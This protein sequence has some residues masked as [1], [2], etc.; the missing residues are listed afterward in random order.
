MK[1]IFSTP[2]AAFFLTVVVA[3]LALLGVSPVSEAVRAMSLPLAAVT[4]TLVLAVYG[5][6]DPRPQPRWW[7]K[8]TFAALYLVA[9]LVITALAGQID[10]WY[11]RFGVWCLVAYLLSGLILAAAIMYH[12]L[13]NPLGRATQRG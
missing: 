3:L 2:F 5:S 8:L 9:V 6:L 13:G 12:T 10:F 11:A 7:D 4:S 1:N